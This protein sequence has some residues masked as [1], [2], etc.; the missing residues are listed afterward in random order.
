MVP[1][2]LEEWQAAFNGRGHGRVVLDAF[3]EPYLGSLTYRPRGVFLALNPGRA[4]LDFQ[5]REAL[6]ATEIELLGSYS[7]W[8][9]TWPYLRDTWVASRGTNQHHS[10][11]LRFL[12]TW[13]EE[14]DLPAST[15]VGFELYPWHSTRVTATMR[16]KANTIRRYVSEPLSELRAP[17]FAFGAPW[18]VILKSDLGLTMVDELGKGGRPYGSAVESRRVVVFRDPRSNLTI[19]AESHQGSAGPPND[20]ETRLLRRATQRHFR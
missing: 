18:Q 8:A 20:D 5:G 9:A 6:F 1:K 2:G 10:R 13:C 11:R 16:P 7:K 3:P 12:R 4:Y 15:M 19:V 17:V 14:P